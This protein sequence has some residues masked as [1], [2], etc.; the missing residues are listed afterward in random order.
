M[1]LLQA[2]VIVT[3]W[4][5][6]SST[7]VKA[8]HHAFL[9]FKEGE[10]P[11]HEV[12]TQVNYDTDDFSHCLQTGT[13]ISQVWDDTGGTIGKKEVSEPGVPGVVVKLLNG[14]DNA[15][16]SMALTD[17]NGLAKFNPGSY[18]LKYS[19]PPGASFTNS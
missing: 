12:G 16:I 10:H 13:I 5:L 1:F 2:L 6:P 18:V 15:L 3:I 8:A 4:S 11:D 9:G 7:H 14:T 19:L 17:V